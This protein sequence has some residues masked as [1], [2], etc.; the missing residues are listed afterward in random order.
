MAEVAAAPPT[1]RAE[2]LVVDAAP[3]LQSPASL[4]GLARKFVTVR[5]VVDEIR[6]R[7]SRD[8]LASADWLGVGHDG[9]ASGLQVRSPTVEALARGALPSS[10]I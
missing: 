1:H 7:T 4:R 6:D 5:A 8:L 10:W 2:T 3:L 9:Q